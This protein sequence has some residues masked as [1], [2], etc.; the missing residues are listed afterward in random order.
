MDRHDDVVAV[1]GE[2]LVD[3]VVDDLEHEVVQAG[4]I[5]GVADVHAGALAHGFQTF[6]DLDAAFAIRSAVGG[7]ARGLF[8][9]VFGGVLGV[10]HRVFHTHIWG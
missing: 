9:S 8:G 5:G 6:E 1:A 4:A 10:A 2:R 7:V 3:R